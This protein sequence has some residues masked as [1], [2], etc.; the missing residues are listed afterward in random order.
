MSLKYKMKVRFNT[1]E[2]KYF[3]TTPLEALKGKLPFSKDIIKQYKKKVQILLCVESVDD[4]KQ[5]RSLNFEA[6]KG[7]RTGFYAI[8]L[9]KQYRLIFKIEKEGNGD[10]TRII[11]FVEPFGVTLR[12]SYRFGD[13]ELKLFTSLNFNEIGVFPS[14]YL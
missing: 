8:R 7:D 2:L 9:N 4:I 14:K 1:K 3:Y 5:F 13:F 11:N 10:L 12:V 6:L